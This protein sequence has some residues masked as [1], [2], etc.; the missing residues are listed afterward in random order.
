MRN[1]TVTC[2]RVTLTKEREYKIAGYLKLLET[3][4]PNGRCNHE[5]ASKVMALRLMLRMRMD[6]QPSYENQ[7]KA[8]VRML[9]ADTSDEE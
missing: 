2:L 4:K 3:A 7:V 9:Y 6:M 5:V 1:T 8:L